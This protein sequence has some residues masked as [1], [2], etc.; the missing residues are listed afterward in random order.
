[1]TVVFIGFAYH[2]LYNA[3]PLKKVSSFRDQIKE[4]LEWIM[5]YLGIL[6]TSCLLI[7]GCSQ[8]S[9]IPRTTDAAFEFSDDGGSDTVLMRTVTMK[10]PLNVTRR[11]AE[12]A[13]TANNFDLRTAS[14]TNE[15]RCG[16][17]AQGR[18]GSSLWSCFYFQPASDGTIRTRV[19]V[20]QWNEFGVKRMSE[21]WDLRLTNALEDRLY[22]V[23]SAPSN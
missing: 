4:S 7:A 3:R 5:M 19:Y 15:R 9:Q 11:A 17:F 12:Y 21:R 16:E 20:E 1:M 23:H 14:R 6:L 8:V 18:G 13:L 22:S 10:A 2:C